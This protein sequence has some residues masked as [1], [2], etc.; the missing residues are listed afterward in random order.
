MTISTVLNQYKENAVKS[1]P[2]EKLVQM[3]YEGAIKNLRMAINYLDNDDRALFGSYLGKGNS[4]VAE[5]LSS[6][7]HDAAPPITKNLEKLYLFVID[8]ITEANLNLNSAGLRQ[9]IKILETLK[10]GWDYAAKQS[11]S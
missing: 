1:A 11:N 5:L 9:S 6:L 2:P 7:D 4:I 10:E 8:R 3:L